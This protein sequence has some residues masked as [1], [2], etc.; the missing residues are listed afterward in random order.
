MGMNIQNKCKVDWCNN[1]QNESGQGYCRRHYDQMR[2]YGHILD[3]RTRYCQNE[4]IT[5]DTFAE[6]VLT[7]D[8]QN[9]MARVLIDLDD[10][11]RVK[12][13][14]WSLKDNGY[15]RTVYN[16]ATTYLHRF[17]LSAGNNGLDV[18]HINHNKLDNRKKNLRVCTRSENAYNKAAHNQYGISGVQKLKR[19]LSK[20]YRA[21]IIHDGKNT[22]L[23]YFDTAEEAEKARLAYENRAGIF[24][25]RNSGDDCQ[26]DSP[27]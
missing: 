6:M 2:K 13:H 25:Y 18:D 22:F 24:I 9:E 27:G 12:E 11:D 8:K 1:V 21:N 23:G 16:G 19:N 10:V 7:D 14:R 15:V 17:V 26:R 5:H 4:I 3:E 20:K